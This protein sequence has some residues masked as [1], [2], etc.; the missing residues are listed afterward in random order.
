MLRHPGTQTL[1][2]ED[3]DDL[4]VTMIVKETIDFGHHHWIDLAQLGRTQGQRQAQT[5]A[6]AAPKAHLDEDLLAAQEGDVFH[7]E[8][9]HA[10]ALPL[11]HRRVPPQAGKVGGQSQDLRPLRL[12]QG[13]AVSLPSALIVGLGVG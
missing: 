3:V 6:S 7:Q 9:Q 10:L 13:T 5:L 11:G 8:A 1:G 4:G 12:A 2:I